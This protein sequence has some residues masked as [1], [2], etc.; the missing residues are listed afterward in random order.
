[1]RQFKLVVAALVAFIISFSSMS[2]LLVYAQDEGD[3]VPYSVQPLLPDNQ[4]N[5]DVTYFDIAMDKGQEQ[6]LEVIVF[7][8]SDQE[9]KVSVATNF[10]ATNRN[11]LIT[12][13]GSIEQYDQSMQFLFSEIAKPRDEELTVAPGELLVTY[14]DIDLPDESFDG[15]ILGGIYFTLLEDEEE[16]EG[17]VGFVNEYSYAIGVNITEKDNNTV[18]TPQLELREVKPELINHR[19]GIQTT[20]ANI[21]PIL[22]SQLEFEGRIYRQDSEEALYTRTVQPFSVGPNNL[23]HFPVSLEDKPLKPG[24]YVFRGHAKNDDHQW[25]FEQTFSIS[26]EESNTINDQAVVLEETSPWNGWLIGAV[27][28]IGL[29]LGVIIYLMYR[30]NTSEQ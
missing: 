28:V 9:I 23:F 16:L 1:M 30:N 21:T 5:S 8:S 17:A 24:D 19:T 25:E 10:A 29:L 15:Q 13:D 12:Y 7:N 14:I 4:V 2:H 3:R 22:I 27:V 26:E 6:S 20:F 11:G 18:V